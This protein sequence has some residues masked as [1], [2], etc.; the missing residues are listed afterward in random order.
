MTR[1]FT[2]ATTGRKTGKKHLRQG[3]TR[4]RRPKKIASSARPSRDARTGTLWEPFN[5]SP[6]EIA[7]IAMLSPPRDLKDWK[8]LEGQTELPADIVE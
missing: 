6:E 4:G 3:H 1:S 5:L 2:T 8:F 7:R